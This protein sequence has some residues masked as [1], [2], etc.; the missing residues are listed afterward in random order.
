MLHQLASQKFVN[1]WMYEEVV[2]SSI[3][4]KGGTSIVK[5]THSRTLK[6]LKMCSEVQNMKKNR[7]NIL[8]Q[9]SLCLDMQGLQVWASC[10]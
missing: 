7:Q 9:A 3:I 10:T 5:W 6:M 8:S 1:V 4:D 2:G